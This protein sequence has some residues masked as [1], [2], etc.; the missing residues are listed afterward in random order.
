MNRVIDWLLA[1]YPR[2]VVVTG[3]MVVIGLALAAYVVFAVTHSENIVIFVVW[4]FVAPILAVT[5]FLVIRDFFYAV[6]NEVETWIPETGEKPKRKNDDTQEYNLED[7]DLTDG[8]LPH[9]TD[10]LSSHIMR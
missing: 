2:R 10:P 1:R 9:D 5:A 6:F 4:M 7:Y 8:E 3:S